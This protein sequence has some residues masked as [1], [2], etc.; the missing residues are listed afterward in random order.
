M[1]TQVNKER[2][3]SR[4]V[5]RYH[6]LHAPLVELIQSLQDLVPQGMTLSDKVE[7]TQVEGY[8]EINQNAKPIRLVINDEN[9]KLTIVME[10][11]RSKP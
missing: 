11:R 4:V 8:I 10:E 5:N 1:R 9:R 3:E 2:A 7:L 6:K